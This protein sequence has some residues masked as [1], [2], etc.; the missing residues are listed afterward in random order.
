ML[1]HNIFDEAFERTPIPGPF[2]GQWA[3]GFHPT[4]FHLIFRGAFLK[5]D[6]PFS[7]WAT[8]NKKLAANSQKKKRAAM[9]L[10]NGTIPQFYQGGS[11][12]KLASS[13]IFRWVYCEQLNTKGVIISST[14]GDT[15]GSE[16]YNSLQ[17]IKND[18]EISLTPSAVLIGYD[19]AGGLTSGAYNNVVVG[20]LAGLNMSHSG[21]NT[22]IGL[23]AGGNSLDGVSNT[24]V[25]DNAM[26]LFATETLGPRSIAQLFA[27]A[28]P[29]L[30]PE[31]LLRD[32]RSPT[33]V[34]PAVDASISNPFITGDLTGATLYQAYHVDRTRTLFMSD[35][36]QPMPYRDI[37]HT[38]GN[39][40]FG[41]NALERLGVFSQYN[42]GLGCGAGEGL[43]WGDN[44]TFVGALCAANSTVARCQTVIGTAAGRNMGTF[45]PADTDRFPVPANPKTRRFDFLDVTDEISYNTLIGCKAGDRI[46]MGTVPYSRGTPT[47][48][49]INNSRNNVLIGH[50]ACSA[51]VAS[52]VT[53]FTGPYNVIVG[54][55]AA[56]VITSGRE[57]VINGFY[58]APVLT[59]GV[60]NVIIGATTPAWATIDHP[61]GEQLL[62]EGLRFNPAV[63]PTLTGAVAPVLTTGSKNVILGKNA[64][65]GLV[66]GDDNIA[67]GTS[68]TV[69]AAVTFGVAIGSGAFANNTNAIAVGINTN[70]GG[71]SAVAI[72]NGTISGFDDAVSIGTSATANADSA[73]AI[74]HNSSAISAA[75]ISIGDGS[76]AAHTDCAVF[77]RSAASLAANTFQVG[78]VAVPMR[79]SES[80]PAHTD[81]YIPLDIAAAVALTWQGIQGG[82]VMGTPAAP[83]LL[84][85]PIAADI[86]TNVMPGAVVGQ[87]VRLKIVNLDAVPANTYTITAGDVNVHIFGNPVIA[88]SDSRDLIFVHTGDAP[89]VIS[90]YM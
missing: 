79:V 71:I 39:S 45:D 82:I 55:H 31:P 78:C 29:P 74:G 20:P 10:S 26:G 77:G 24:S 62:G 19:V 88:G 67:I 2:H 80:A 1:R 44:N 40:A 48:P 86:Y 37:P 16:Q 12:S 58:A 64:G 32:P 47:D 38:G 46:F 49:S 65:V 17:I 73:I 15:P 13:G 27:Q 81:M 5:G 23:A 34:L 69:G 4:T 25:G 87:G 28:G 52:Y 83:V 14:A 42:T 35:S 89:V 72:G 3:F 22:F 36:Q 30:I 68:S 57:N 18:T 50:G 9:S 56:P 66:S 63:N 33:A 90:I 8:K 84:T 6:E 41:S 61:F 7:L 76:A 11:Q 85:T 43:Q 60:S 59:S 70:S 51:Y 53:H 75:A 21:T 54:S